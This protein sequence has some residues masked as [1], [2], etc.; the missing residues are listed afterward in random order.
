MSEVK[1]TKNK[2]NMLKIIIIVLLGLILVGGAAFA[3][4]YFASKGSTH[5]AAANVTIVSNVKETYFEAIKE[6]L[7]NLADTDSKRYAKLSLTIAYDSKNK[8]I[9]AELEEK[10]DAIEDAIINTIRNKKAA[11]FQGKG[12]EDLKKEILTRV[13]ALLET[14]KATNIYYKDL[15]IQ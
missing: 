5:T 1:K 2:G 13:N 15:L 12:A 11:D 10:V 4:Y 3:G 14:G 8:K 9:A 7:I 6:K